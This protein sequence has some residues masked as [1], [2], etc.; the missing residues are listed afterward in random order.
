MQ[1]DDTLGVKHILDAAQKA[2]ALSK[3][4]TREDMDTHEM[5]ALSLVRLL[6]IIGEAANGVSQNF[7]EKYPELPWK[8]MIELR[9]R[10]IHGYFDI[11]L[12]I[13]WDT[14]QKDLPPLIGGLKDIL[15]REG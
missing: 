7:R 6:E 11:N 5:L 2:V 13:V 3:A 15:E 8:R 12:D 10:L 4:H 9:N 14:V 1:R